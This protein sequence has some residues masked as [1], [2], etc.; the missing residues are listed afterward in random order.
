MHVAM[1]DVI[2]GEDNLE[3]QLIKKKQ[4]VLE[5]EDKIKTQK[6]KKKW[7]GV[8]D[9]GLSYYEVRSGAC[10]HGGVYHGNIHCTN[11]NCTK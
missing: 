4:E 3:A 7:N 6:E 11:P 2:V 5:L 1:G 8:P 9:C 10:K